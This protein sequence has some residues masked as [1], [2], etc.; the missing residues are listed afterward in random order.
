MNLIKAVE[1]M[2]NIINPSAD[3]IRRMLEDDYHVIVGAE[4]NYGYDM[5]EYDLFISSGVLYIG[6]MSDSESDKIVITI[7]MAVLYDRRVIDEILPGF[8]SDM[9]VFIVDTVGYMHEAEINCGQF[10]L[11]TIKSQ[12]KRG[13]ILNL[14]DTY[15][16]PHVSS[17]PDTKVYIEDNPDAPLCGKDAV[18]MAAET[19]VNTKSIPNKKAADFIILILPNVTKAPHNNFYEWLD[20]KT[21]DIPVVADT[22]RKKKMCYG[23]PHEILLYWSS[24]AVMAGLADPKQALY[25]CASQLD[26]AITEFHQK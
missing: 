25:K 9:D 20:D 22:L 7:V 17:H 18:K 4:N 13:Q 5:L 6:K 2:S 8:L 24:N 15:S 12:L 21:K 26:D 10:E 3:K 14:V 16:N 23:K 19:V 1:E 11:E